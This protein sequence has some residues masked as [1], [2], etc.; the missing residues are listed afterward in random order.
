MRKGKGQPIVG[1]REKRKMTTNNKTNTRKGRGQLTTRWT[2]EKEV[3][4]QQQDEHK[5]R[6]WATNNKNNMR[7]EKDD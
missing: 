4:N 3:G 7:K 1:H 6:K 5:K 2:Q